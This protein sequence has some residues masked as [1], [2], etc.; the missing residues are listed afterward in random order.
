MTN[1]ISCPVCQNE[2]SSEAVAC[3]KCGHP[4]NGNSDTYQSEIFREA[5]ISTSRANWWK[6]G[7]VALVVLLLGVIVLGLSGARE[8]LNN[9]LFPTGQESSSNVAQT[10]PSPE[11]LAIL[12]LE[13]G[14]DYQ[15]GGVQPVTSETFYLLDRDLE[16][17]LKDS[18]IKPSYG[19]Y[20]GAYALGIQFWPNKPEQRKARELISEHTKYSAQTD[21]KG[22]A[23]L[24][25]IR[26]DTY[27]L[28]GFTKTRGGY[29]I[30]N[31]RVI[32]KSGVNSQILDSKNAAEAF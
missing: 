5:R 6:I 13:A 7:T 26:P 18:K 16:E 2:C 10:A 20:Y 1:L 8:F 3:P 32:L 23:R 28:F 27:Y 22:K 12:D 24:V 30:W 15:M 14:I 29:A 11:Q 17:I 21:L 4:F 19:S 25:N 31:S 9:Y